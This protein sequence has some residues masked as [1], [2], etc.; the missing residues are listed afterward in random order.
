MRSAPAPS[1]PEAAQCKRA[2]LAL[3]SSRS[4]LRKLASACAMA[5]L[6]VAV[7]SCG[8]GGGSDVAGPTPSPSPSPAPSPTPAP[9]PAAQGRAQLA[10]SQPGDL[11][12]YVRELVRANGLAAVESGAVM[13]NVSFASLVA[14]GGGALP[15]P[16]AAPSPATTASPSPGSGDAAAGNLFS[17]TQVQEQ[18]VDEADWVKTDGQRLYGFKPGYYDTAIS[19]NQ[20]ARLLLQTRQ[21]DGQLAP[22]QR[23]ELA[24]NDEYQGMYLATGAQRMALLSERFELISLPPVPVSPTTTD[25]KSITALPSILPA[26][27]KSQVRLQ[28]LPAQASGTWTVTHSISIDGDLQGSR[29]IG[30][31]L[32]V[33]SRWAPYLADL[34]LSTP[35]GATLSTARLA[36]L[37]AAQILPT[38]RIN[39]G[40]AQP[41]HA[42]TDCYTQARNASPYVELTSITV[43]NLADSNAARASKC[44]VGGTEAMYVSTQ[45]IYLAN[46]R[47]YYTPLSGATVFNNQGITDVHKFS[48]QGMDISYKASGEVNGNLG[49][50]RD[51]AAYR[52][53]EYQGDLRIV[54]FT[55]GFNWGGWVVPMPAG[56]AVTSANV[57]VPST[58]PITTNAQVSP[59]TLSILRE[60]GAGQL[61]LVGSLPNASQTQPIGKPGE[62]VYAVKFIGPRAYV[63]TFRR[64]DPLY[65]LDL[66]NPASPKTVG[67]LEIPGFSD[68][69]Y[70]MS[71][72]LLLGV[73]KDADASGRVAGIKL[74]L[75]NV[76][77]P[78]E[79]TLVAQQVLGQ[80]G[81]QSALDYSSRGISIFKQGAVQRIALPIR[82]QTSSAPTLPTAPVSQGLYRFEVDTSVPAAQARLV[83]KPVVG[84]VPLRNTDLQEVFGLRDIRYDRAV[85][86]AE[87]VYY[88]AAGVFQ[89][90]KW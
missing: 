75:M 26:P 86:F 29:L 24:G 53:S 6:A 17:G 27:G 2:E 7:A 10:A 14:A 60:A 52:M 40:P 74:A 48:L 68:Y 87:D 82:I 37:T 71:D 42:E 90:A 79:P 89:S 28:L 34:Y 66:S 12:N 38:I 50:N 47:N 56:A 62:Q 55:G 44:F 57:I 80:A 4:T 45:N 9:S 25:S 83:S 11:T 43:F 8:G 5:A 84:E 33:V 78:A 1:Q 36:S 21:A 39:N 32:Y 88:F 18:G 35:S 13:N 22:A 72:G 58:Q 16:T 85:Q 76:S 41:L 46:S 81:S 67:Q 3:Q 59:A 64:T 20:P 54:S 15:A 23:L 73:G 65:V 63:V 61:S 51:Q 77:N 19:A 30:N 70:P 49:W 31:H 69:L